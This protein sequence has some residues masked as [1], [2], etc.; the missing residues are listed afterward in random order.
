[1]MWYATAGCQ[2]LFGG[3]SSSGSSSPYVSNNV[4][5]GHG[6]VFTVDS[7][8]RYLG[9][10]AIEVRTP[11]NGGGY[12]SDWANIYV[13]VRGG[14]AIRDAVIISWTDAGEGYTW[15]SPEGTP[16]TFAGYSSAAQNRSAIFANDPE[17]EA[18]YA[19]LAQSGFNMNGKYKISRYQMLASPRIAYCSY[20]IVQRSD[21]PSGMSDDQLMSYMLGQANNLVH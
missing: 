8:F 12:D 14:P 9:H 16:V 10:R 6:L 19:F 20:Y 5:H 17:N 7:S 21:I 13:F 4:Y 11:V 18:V 2:P 15:N 3:G 1:M